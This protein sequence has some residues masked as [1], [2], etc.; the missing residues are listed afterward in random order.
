MHRVPCDGAAMKPPSA[1]TIGTSSFGRGTRPGSPGEEQAARLAE[2]SLSA[3]HA[4]VDTSNN[5]AD[6]R[7]EAVLGIAIA[8]L[9]RRRTTDVI[10][11]VDADPQSRR[12][13]RDRV[14]RSFEESTV[15]LGI[16]RVR[17]LHLHDPDMLT[18]SEALGPNGAVEGMVELRASG[19]VDA[20]GIAGGSVPMMFA[21]LDSGVFDAVLCH[22]RYTLIDQSA[23]PL[24]EEA[25]RR[26][27]TVFNAAPFGAGI[28]STGAHPSAR[29]A[30]LPADE[31]LQRWVRRL[32]ELCRE[33]QV[34]LPA[35]ALSFSL[36]SP[37]VDSTVVGVSSS[38]RL[39]KLAE[40][41]EDDIPDAFWSQLDSL[42]PAPS[43]I[44][45]PAVR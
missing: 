44:L 33:H 13:D 22:N 21:Y 17:L 27:M 15:R 24:F 43:P 34:T 23:Q 10:T 45:D 40:L 18:M 7:S 35:A 31:L 42:G 1:L 36:R 32:E 37:L 29:Y 25:R 8:R 26:R 6:G 4:Y 14:L 9:G 3:G 19:S 41:T 28:L 16:D 5:Y 2:A 30:Y 39:L 38:A 11:K 20:I 12:F